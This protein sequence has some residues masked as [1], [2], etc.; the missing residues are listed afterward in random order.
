M[1]KLHHKSSLAPEDPQQLLA[2]LEKFVSGCRRPAVWEDG[3]EPLELKRGDYFL[4]IRGQRLWIEVVGIVTTFGRRILNLQ[5]SKPGS[6]VCQVQR[7]GRPPG[8]LTFLDLDRPTNAQKLV[9]SQRHTF[10]ERFRLMLARQF[11][12]WNIDHLSS[13]LDLRRSFSSVFPRA[14]LSRGNQ[15]IA[16]LACP[17]AADESGFLTTALL[18]FDYLK[19]TLD[20]G[21]VGRLALFL[22]EGAGCLSTQ[23]LRWLSAP[24]REAALYLFNEHGSAGQ[25]DAADLGNLESRVQTPAARSIQPHLS[26]F[27]KPEAR[28]EA[29][30]RQHLHLLDATL[31]TAPVHS[32]ILTFVAGDRNLIDLLAVSNNG[33]L[34]V[35]ELKVSEDLH[36][37]MQALDYWMRI[38]WHAHRAELQPLFPFTELSLEPP[39]LML[40]APA[41][42]FHSTNT[43]ILKYFS[44]QIEVERIGV[45]SDWYRRLTV[46]LR[47]QA[48]DCPISHQTDYHVHPRLD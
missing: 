24:A 34:S 19:A 10:A 47:L 11:P 41:Q 35:I 16:A 18:W 5:D 46:V 13:A 37:P 30:V 29:A 43:T 9:S 23:R 25:V 26:D 36:L 2:V 7:F 44:P 28:L 17:S 45:N 48:A 27:D 12:G 22:P 1:T 33:R 38:H 32:Q 40:V 15:V 42:A 20:T 39:R 3:A 6:I 4:E 31:L 21:G 8:R 14:R